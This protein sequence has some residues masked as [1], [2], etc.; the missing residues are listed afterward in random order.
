MTQIDPIDFCNIAVHGPG[1]FNLVKMHDVE[2]ILI[3]LKKELL[4]NGLKKYG[5][6]I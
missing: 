5:S 4:Y 3:L 6:S 1:H 2:Y